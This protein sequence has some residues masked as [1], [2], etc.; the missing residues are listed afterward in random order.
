MIKFRRAFGNGIEHT[1]AGHDFASGIKRDIDPA[2]RQSGDP[3]GQRL[4]SD[5]RSGQVLG[6]CRNKFP[7]AHILRDGRGGKGCRCCRAKSA[8]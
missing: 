7:F 2:T 3:V 4:R 5:T 8:C 1:I 6:P